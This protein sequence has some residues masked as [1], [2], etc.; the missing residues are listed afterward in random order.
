[1]LAISSQLE[2]GGAGTAVGA[3][4]VLACV[5]AQAARGGPAFIYICG[6]AT[7]AGG[8]LPEVGSLH[9]QYKRGLEE[10]SRDPEKIGREPDREGGAKR[11]R[12]GE[13]GSESVGGRLEAG[14]G[15]DRHSK[16]QEKRATGTR[17]RRA[18]GAE[19]QLDKRQ[20]S[21]QAQRGQ[22]EVGAC[23][24]EAAARRLAWGKWA[25]LRGAG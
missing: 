1:M 13:K 12:T 17:L 22:G 9:P 10:G 7:K 25:P 21:S 14:R 19:P 18:E 23:R 3:K 20:E 11:L 24:K 4:R 15:T 5:L 2:A 6:Q 8:Q 16:G